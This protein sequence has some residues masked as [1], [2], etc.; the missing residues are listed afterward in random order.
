MNRLLYILNKRNLC[1]CVLDWR[2][3]KIYY[4][5]NKNN[6]YFNKY[7]EPDDD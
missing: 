4:R 3:D 6:E 1:L 2:F 7:E 5:L